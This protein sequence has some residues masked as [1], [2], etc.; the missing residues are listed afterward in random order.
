LCHPA[1]ERSVFVV[2]ACSSTGTTPA[3]GAS[4]S[5]PEGGSGSSGL[6]ISSLATWAVALIQA[7]RTFRKSRDKKEAKAAFLAIVEKRT[8]GIKAAVA[9]TPYV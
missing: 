3:M 7:H 1:K 2:I 5:F 4:E 6:V 8:I 9:R